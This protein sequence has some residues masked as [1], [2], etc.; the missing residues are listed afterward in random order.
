[1]ITSRPYREPMSQARALQELRDGAGS[2]FDPH[3]VD[4]LLT[5]LAER[6]ALVGG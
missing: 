1:M 4:V 5:V 6:E 3:V 2:Q